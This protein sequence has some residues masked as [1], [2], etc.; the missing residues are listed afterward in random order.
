MEIRIAVPNDAATI[1]SVL[2]DSFAAFETFY[3]PEAFSATTP[4]ANQIQ[5]R[6]NEGPV[7]VAIHNDGI[8]GTVAAVLKTEGVYVRGMAVLPFARG[9]GI[10]RGL[11]RQIE[12]FASENR[13]SRLILSTTPFLTDAI[14]LYE[15]SGFQRSDEGPHELFGT[16]LFTMVKHLESPN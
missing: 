2:Y 15:Q 8:V 16:P 7:W 14:R 6:M 13:Q 4:K 9:L 5:T 1:E 3:T 11:L 12:S 10:A